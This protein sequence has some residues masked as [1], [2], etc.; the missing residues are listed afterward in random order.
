MLAFAAACGGGGSKGLTSDAAG[1][2]TP[3]LAGTP[4]PTAV[5][6]TSG[7]SSIETTL[8]AGKVTAKVGA[9]AVVE[10]T[11]TGLTKPGLGA[12]TFDLS[13][14]PGIVSVASCK[15]GANGLSVCNQKASGTTVRVAGAAALGLLG[16]QTL[17]TVTFKCKAAGES[18]LILTIDTFAD[19]TRGAPKTVTPTLQDGS[20][21]CS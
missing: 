5:G 1:N 4:R 15:E 21:T 12:W 10:V 3:V 2:Q 16:D 8:S 13:Y 9:N 7:V 14:D 19:A 20:L 17:L 18:P 11:A 6:D